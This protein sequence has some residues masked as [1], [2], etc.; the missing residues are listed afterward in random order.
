MWKISVC[1]LLAVYYCLPLD[2]QTSSISKFSSDLSLTRRELCVRMMDGNRVGE[3]DVGG[4]IADS[5][6][7]VSESILMERKDK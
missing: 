3:R 1:S 6:V 4:L 2:L 7:L 5:S